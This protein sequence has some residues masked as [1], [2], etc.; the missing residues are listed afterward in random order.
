MQVIGEKE[1]HHMHCIQIM[2][3]ASWSYMV[4]LLVASKPDDPESLVNPFPKILD[5]ASYTD[6]NLHSLV[7]ILLMTSSCLADDNFSS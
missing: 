1:L 2:D 6:M 3:R 5:K 7:Y 4:H